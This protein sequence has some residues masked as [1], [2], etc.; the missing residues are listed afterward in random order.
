MFYAFLVLVFFVVVFLARVVFAGAVL[1]FTG[2][3][4]FFAAFFGLTA[5]SISGSTAAEARIASSGDVIFFFGAFFC[6]A[7]A[8]GFG[9]GFFT[10]G[11]TD[12]CFAGAGLATGRLPDTFIEFLV[13]DGIFFL[14][15]V[16]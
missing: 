5:F 16:C 3:F 15:R 9:F 2:A 8:T 12:A 6:L 11:S 14:L 1:A 7:A 13:L 10:E 4:F